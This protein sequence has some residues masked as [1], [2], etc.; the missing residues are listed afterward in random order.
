ML[1][2][3]E[4]AL[5][6][7]RLTKIGAVILALAAPALGPSVGWAAQAGQ[8]HLRCVNVVGGASWS[9]IVDLDHSVVDS[10]PAKISDNWISWREPNAG[11]FE[12]ERATGK[13]QLRAAS[14]T[15]GFFLHYT[16]QPE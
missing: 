7:W 1:I 15:G 2:S 12:L 9:I 3:Q 16:C 5:A 10:R 8:L 4:K 13:L 14:S 11:I 6:Q